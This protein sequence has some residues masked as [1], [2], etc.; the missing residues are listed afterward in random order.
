MPFVLAGASFRGWQTRN[1]RL[2]GPL[3]GRTIA[4]PAR[5]AEPESII[6]RRCAEEMRRLGVTPWLERDDWIGELPVY[7]FI[8]PRCPAP[9]DAVTSDR[10]R[11]A[12]SIS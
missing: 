1:G 12:L 11:I 8:L 7:F 6:P 2:D 9:T 5:E 4:P 10:L 3:A